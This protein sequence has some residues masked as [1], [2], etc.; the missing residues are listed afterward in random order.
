MTASTIARISIVRTMLAPPPLEPDECEVLGEGL[1][2]S[3]VLSPPFL[4]LGENAETGQA[5]ASRHAPDTAVAC[6]TA[7]ESGISLIIEGRLRGRVVPGYR[8]V[9]GGLEGTRT[10]A[11]F[12]CSGAQT[13]FWSWMPQAPSPV[14]TRLPLAKH[15]PLA[16]SS[17]GAS[18]SWSSS[19]TAPT[20]SSSA[21]PIGRWVLREFAGLGP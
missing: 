13:S 15:S 16:N 6:A 10:G 20:V 1:R 4:V 7:R 14:T 8:P 19:H 2:F 5:K 11:P 21:C 18:A 17:T 3:G 12:R 9:G